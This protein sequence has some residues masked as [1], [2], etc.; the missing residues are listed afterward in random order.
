MDLKRELEELLSLEDGEDLFSSVYLDTSV[1]SDG[2][3][4]HSLFVKQKIGLLTQV[5]RHRKGEAAVR[6]FR[7][8]VA[9][10]EEYLNQK[11]ERDTRGLALFCSTRRG[12]F[13][14]LQLPVPLRNK[15]A[16]SSSPN[17]DVLIE[18]AE[19]QHQYAVAVFDQHS[20]RVFSIHLNRHA[21]REASLSEDVPGRT[22]VGGWS[23]M[24]YQR[25]RKDLIQ[26]FMRDFAEQLDQFDRRVK[27]RGL[28]LL[29]TQENLAELKRHL[30]QHLE[31]KV[32]LARSLPDHEDDQELIEKVRGFVEEF[33]AKQS[34]AALARFYD[35]LSQDY[36][37]VI[38]LDETLFNLQMGKVERLF[39][40]DS[41]NGQ[42]YRCTHCQFVF[43][44]DVHKCP[45]CRGSAEP[46][47]IRNRIEKLAE[48]HGAYLQL[49]DEATFLDEFG[50]VGG[51]L[52][53]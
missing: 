37:T 15:F 49:L 8:H 20:G 6:E 13:K 11:L 26:H 32:V 44:R 50:G 45:Y 7:E 28:V 30:P 9:S 21:G 1:S 47:D 23:Q 12:Y 29:G 19:E 33:E 5:L 3:R 31:E 35:R 16:V 24:R 34:E 17:L 46:V 4:T 53:F 40:S 27:P 39:I 36:Q 2:Q 43:S 14:A 42:G 38:G 25:H 22:K 41:L 10:I 51:M 52:K 48:H 18:L